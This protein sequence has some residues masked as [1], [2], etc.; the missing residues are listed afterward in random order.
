MTSKLI[1]GNTSYLLSKMRCK[2]IISTYLQILFNEQSAVI[3]AMTE[4]VCNL[5]VYSLS[6]DKKPVAV[7]Q[8]I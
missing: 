7:I 1:N 2:Q 8:D 4:G 6:T 5:F 3:S